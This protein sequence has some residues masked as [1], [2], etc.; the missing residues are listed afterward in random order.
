VSRSNS[1]NTIE[2]VIADIGDSNSIY[3]DLEG[4]PFI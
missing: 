4:T 2:E 1:V 3:L